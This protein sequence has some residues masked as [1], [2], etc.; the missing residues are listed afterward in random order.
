MKNTNQRPKQKKKMTQADWI[1]II[2]GFSITTIIFQMGSFG[3]VSAFLI[4]MI[5]YWVVKEIALFF[6]KE[7]EMKTPIVREKQQETGI[8]QKTENKSLNKKWVQIGFGIIVFIVIVGTSSSL[9]VS[10]EQMVEKITT[11][12]A[13]QVSI[14]GFVKYSGEDAGLNF[15]VLFPTSNPESFNLDLEEGYIKSYQAP[16]IIDL[17]ERKFVQYS[18]FFSV[19]KE[20]KIL[21]EESIRAYL[22]NYPKGKSVSSGGTLKKENMTTYKGLTAIEYVFNSEIQDTAMTHKGIVFV[23]DGI[24]IDLSVVYTNITP[25]SSI[26]YDSYI[27]SFAILGK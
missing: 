9:D 13:E 24:P 3:F 21:G 8:I 5:S 19:R 15:S 26:Y 1:G 10:N 18:V 12:Q 4:A 16:D 22:E 7:N 27:K 11:L 23:V 14:P 25:A 17:E 6:T 20:G 2:G